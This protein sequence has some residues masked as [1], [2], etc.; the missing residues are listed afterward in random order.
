LQDVSYWIAYSFVN[1]VARN[2]TWEWLKDNWAWLKENMGS[3][4]SYPR[5]PMYAA[6]AFSD[7]SFIKP[8]KKFFQKVSEPGLDRAIKQGLETIKM[9][10][11]WRKHDEQPLLDYLARG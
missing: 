1:P 3:D 9:Q 4:M 2:L 7:K 10:A 8:Y 6:R 11:G 5:L